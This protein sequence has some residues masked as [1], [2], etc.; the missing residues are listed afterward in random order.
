MKC[1][2][3]DHKLNKLE[4]LCP[5]CHARLEKS[6]YNLKSTDQ[7]LKEITNIREFAK[8]IGLYYIKSIILL[9]I[10][11]FSMGIAIFLF[12]KYNSRGGYMI[13]AFIFVIAF[14]LFLEMRKVEIFYQDFKKQNNK[15]IILYPFKTEHTVI[16]C[17]ASD[18]IVNSHVLDQR[19]NAYEKLDNNIM[20]LRFNTFKFLHP[21][22]V[23]LFYKKAKFHDRHFNPQTRHFI[24]TLDYD[25]NSYVKLEGNI[26]GFLITDKGAITVYNE[27]KITNKYFK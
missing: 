13:G 17:D 8:F 23:K 12:A 27:P 9:F 25:D 16:V 2:N 21:Q 11:L 14:S 20:L 22:R 15:Y 24:K 6:D 10:A 4:K 26:H 5:N 19:L 1:Y 18:Q 3:C 7:I